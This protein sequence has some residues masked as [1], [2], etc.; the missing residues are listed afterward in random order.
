M[1]TKKYSGKTVFGL[2]IGTRS[3]VG[4]VGY[5][6]GDTFYVLAQR[7]RE[8]ETRAML[9]GQIHDIGKV[10]RTIGEVKLD[11]EEATGLKLDQVCIAAAGRVLRTVNVHVEIEFPEA[12]NVTAEDIFEL[13]TE[14][15]Q[16]AYEEFP[17][18]PVE[19][20]TKFHCVGN[21]IVRYYVNGNV[22]LNPEEHKAE[23]IGVDMIATFLP[24]DVVDGLYKAVGVADLEVA[25]LT[26]E[27][28][29]AIQ[30]AI[31]E[32]FRMLNLA[33]VDVGA[34]TSDICITKDGA[35]VAYGMI[36]SA[37]DGLT[38]VIAKACLV[39]FATAETIKRGISEADE[40]EYSDIMGLPQKITKERVLEI[41]KS[42]VEELAEAA[43]KRIKELNGDQSV[44][45]VFVVG[46]GGKIPG[47]TEALAKYMGIL[48]E[49]VALRGEEVMQQIIFEEDNITKDSLLVTPI[50][51]CLNY[52]EQSNNFIFV[53]FNKERIKLYN[54][55]KLAVVDA[56]LQA[57][58]SNEMMFPRRGKSLNFTV[59]GKNR[60]VKGQLGEAAV[61]K[62][63]GKDS[64]IYAPIHEN[65]VITVHPSTAGAPGEQTIADLQEFRD[66]ISVQVQDK[67]VDVPKFARVNG[68]YQTG[69]YSIQDGDVIEILDWCSVAQILEFTDIML[70]EN[71]R[72]FVN[73][74][75]GDR[76]TKVYENYLLSW[77]E[78]PEATTYAELA[79][80]EE[81]PENEGETEAA[82]DAA[83]DG[84][85]SAETAE[86]AGEGKTSQGESAEKKDGD[87]T[88]AS[89]TGKM[90]P[91]T[92]KV[93]ANAMPVTLSGKSE[94]V[95]VDVFDHI[96]FDLSKPQGSAVVTRLNG[97][98]AQ[99][100]EKLHSGDVLEIFWQK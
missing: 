98:D 83:T 84:A 97:H 27:P 46:G 63:G 57:D 40:V 71:A 29:A 47:Y 60:S 70:P 67:R 11:L 6:K 45:A 88:S 61:I 20:K 64:N 38:E 42:S 48:P 92:I 77:K 8:H 31:P 90:P 58:F 72:I 74:K 66:I 52:Y 80:E 55:D 65:D 3:I 24:D 94:Y 10:G 28:I 43:S 87:S 41:T 82:T 39:D 26:L 79:D 95:F 22:I 17:E 15:I 16:K 19:D 53:T 75:P 9:D 49:R 30:V 59:N 5:K 44:S 32:K 78:I 35:V 2:D 37:G 18:G 93:T 12:K 25:S 36:P 85:E 56:A 14:G 34:G 51:I 4:T 21:S 7:V 33:L 91:V 76:D 68:T 96:D 99:Y 54:N 86:N 81:Q 13:K 62:I 23:T 1:T 73:N 69:Y 100:M 50:G 89:I